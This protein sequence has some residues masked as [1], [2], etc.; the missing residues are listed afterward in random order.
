MPTRGRNSGSPSEGLTLSQAF[1]LYCALVCVITHQYFFTFRLVG[2]RTE[3][4]GCVLSSTNTAT[5]QKNIQR[6]FG[7][8][9]GYPVVVGYIV[10][11]CK[12]I[13]YR[14]KHSEVSALKVVKQVQ[15]LKELLLL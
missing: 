4:N 3:A 1:T 15:Q 7:I 10:E 12:S 14:L 2:T 13:C 9:I 8:K 6:L 11:K 5:Q